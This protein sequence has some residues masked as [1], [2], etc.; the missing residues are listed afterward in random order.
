[1][2]NLL[3]LVFLTSLLLFRLRAEEPVP[4]STPNPFE[5]VWVGTVTSPN[6]QTE[7]GFT[8]TRGKS[9]PGLNASFSMPAM[10]LHEFQL[11]AAEIAD[12]TYTQPDFGAKLTLTDGRLVGTL[13]NPLLHVELHRGEALAAPS[14]APDLPPAPPPAWTHALGAET[15]GSPVARDGMVYIGCVDGKFHALRAPDGSE[16]WVWAGPNPL[17]GAAL[18]TDDSLYVLDEHNDLVSLHRADGQLRWRVPL[19]DEKFAGK[20]ARKNPTF[21]RRVP[22][23]VLV[24]GTL[25][26][27]SPDHGLYALDAPT[28]KILWRHEIGASID[29]AVAAQGDDLI[30]G[31][32]DGSVV[33][34]N[35]L[36]GAESARTKLG[37]P[38]ASAPVIAGDTILVGCRDY[39]LYGLRR[40][41]L[42]VAWRDS[43]W[44]SWVESVPAVVDSIAYIGGSDFRRISAVEPA[45][46]RF[47]WSTDVRGIAWCTPVVT[48]DTVYACT[49]AQTPAAIHHE[50][51]IVALDR[52]TGAVK[53]RQFVPL[54]APA[55]RAG[56]IGSLVLV[57]EKIIGASFDGIV[58]AYP[59]K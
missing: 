54:N 14:P 28:G 44:F 10:F 36:T 8:F 19:Y 41:D 13:G 5:G 49:S 16:S 45:T 27:G 34:L 26:I 33:V 48:A 58:T 57:E 3:R 47:L 15:W 12:G 30:A 52:H 55:E 29:G 46:G 9:G 7:I 22:V 6:D 18:V 59:A 38:I 11:G 42:G 39:L 51:G 40:S 4:A 1:M 56:Y 35:R 21:N 25:Y 32:A 31:C 53:W 20:P 17:Y 23:P 37:R 24:D 43:Y 2:R 50:G